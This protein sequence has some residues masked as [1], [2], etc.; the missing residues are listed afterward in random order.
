MRKGL[1]GFMTCA[2]M[3]GCMLI[4]HA[5]PHNPSDKTLPQ[6]LSV[7]PKHWRDGAKTA[8]EEIFAF[9]QKKS[10]RKATLPSYPSSSLLDWLM[11]RYPYRDEDVKTVSSESLRALYGQVGDDL[12]I[13]QKLLGDSNEQQRRRG[14]RTASFIE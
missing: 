3:S 11:E 12:Q 14:L 13:A 9:L 6:K 1:I 10:E 4:A 5:N 2:I 7:V 8:Q